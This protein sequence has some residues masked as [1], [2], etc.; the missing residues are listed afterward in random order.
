MRWRFGTLMAYSAQ[1]RI[2]KHGSCNLKLAK[3]REAIPLS[4][5]C[6][7]PGINDYGMTVIKKQFYNPL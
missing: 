4:A 2:V 6:R 7:P 1:H 5:V 3:S